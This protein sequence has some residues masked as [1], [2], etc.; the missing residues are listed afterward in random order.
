MGEENN[1]EQQQQQVE[2]YQEQQEPPHMTYLKSLLPTPKSSQVTLM[3]DS[4]PISILDQHAHSSTDKNVVVTLIDNPFAKM[5][6][7]MKTSSRMGQLQTELAG[8]LGIHESS[9]TLIV[10]SGPFYRKCYESDEICGKVLVKGI[11]SFGQVCIPLVVRSKWMPGFEQLS[12]GKKNKMGGRAPTKKPKARVYVFY[13]PGDAF[14]KDWADY[15]TFS[16]EWIE[17]ITYE[18][19]G[20]GERHEEGLPQDLGALALDAMQGL[21]STLSQ[22]KPGAQAEIAPFAFV[23]HGFGALVMIEIAKLCEQH[24]QIRPAS[25]FVLDRPAPS[26]P[27]LS[28]H[29]AALLKDDPAAFM[30]E[31]IPA[32]DESKSKDFSNFAVEQAKYMGMGDGA[33]KFACPIYVYRASQHWAAPGEAEKKSLVSAKDTY[34]DWKNSTHNTAFV[35]NVTTDYFSVR[36]HGDFVDDLFK[37]MGGILQALGR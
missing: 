23:G 30:A 26:H 33:Y 5:V 4:N 34:E 3:V 37:K 24:H 35:K 20:H 8:R 31:W 36:L 32:T 7:T 17:V 29:G 1:E 11:S 28:E 9:F 19:P 15:M 12:Q 13:G 22:H 18:W 25:V 16:P 2:E 10:K 21:N 27:M 6:L 14:S